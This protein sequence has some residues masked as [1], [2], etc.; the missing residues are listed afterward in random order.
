FADGLFNWVI[1]LYQAHGPAEQAI[2]AQLA[3]VAMLTTG[4]TTFVEAGTLLDPDAV[5]AAIAPIGMRGRIG[6]W[7]MDRA[8]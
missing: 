6:R 2:A 5:R 7:I 3:V 4:T 1:P 8:F